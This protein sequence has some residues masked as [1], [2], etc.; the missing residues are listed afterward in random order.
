MT[1][2]DRKHGCGR[3]RQW[4]AGAIKQRLSILSIRMQRHIA[5]CPRCRRLAAGNSRLRLALL[6]LRT[7]PHS[8]ELLMQ[9]NCRAIGVLKRNL[10]DLPKAEKLRH[11]M[12]EPSLFE[13]LS[14]YTQS[15]SYAA[16][17]LVVLLMIRTGIFS[18]M[19]KLHEQGT[20][21]IEQYYT[22]NLDEDILDDIL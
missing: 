10:R 15:V 21:A 22:H 13:R 5:D 16:A 11:A 7:Q 19:M 18:G 2:L 14:K 20:Q 4:L 17:C 6:L 3:I 8:P 9:A 12:V 1:C